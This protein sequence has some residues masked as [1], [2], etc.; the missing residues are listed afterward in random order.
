MLVPVL[1]R[2]ATEIIQSE[3]WRPS[4]LVLWHAGEPMSIGHDWYRNA[5]KILDGGTGRVRRIQFQSNATLLD[6]PWIEL[7]SESK[8][9]IG[10]S[11]DGPEWLH[12]LHRKDR[13]GRGTFDGAMRGVE[14]LK[15]A[16]IPFTVIA[17]VTRN[18][19]DA[20]DEIFDFFHAL[21]PQKL[22]FSIEEAEGANVRSSLYE[23]ETMSRVE[24]FFRQIATRNFAH[25]DPL[26]IREIEGV[27]AGLISPVGRLEGSQET[28]LGRIVAIGATG[29]VALF[30]P[31]LLTTVRG[32]GSYE[33]VGNI[34]QQTLSEIFASD[35]VLKQK[36]LIEFGVR[37]C[38]NTCGFFD[39]CG[40]GSPA[41]KLFETGRYDVNETWYCRI[42]RQATVRGI[43]VAIQQAMPKSSTP[44]M[45]NLGVLKR[46]VAPQ[47]SH[48]PPNPRHSKQ[49]L[50]ILQ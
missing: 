31:E 11:V 21:R 32:D 1:R 38:R 35:A 28:Q 33:T 40:G 27:I 10:V 7:L 49:Q 16:G 12:N 8:A 30:S 50:I 43:E 39:Q 29:N 22:A 42:A 19:L 46:R 15:A 26:R 45:G 6:E 36:E 24:E 18:S 2:V 44:E 48:I 3:Y 13:S 17:T 37:L 34:L 5:H 25:A 41:N 47:S 14:R 4:S 23:I 20:P 9:G